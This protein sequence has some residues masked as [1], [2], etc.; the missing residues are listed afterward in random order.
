MEG[1]TPVSALLHAAT[2]VTAGVFLIIRSSFFIEYSE[3]VLNL[4]IIFGCITTFF[5]GLV[6]VYQYDIKKVI[7]YSTCS[8]LGY[9]FISSGLSNYQLAIFHLF[10]HAFFKALLFLSAGVIIHAFFG[11]QDMRK[12]GGNIFTITPFVYTYFVIGSLA[13]MGF[14]YLTGFFS[15]ELIIELGY[16]TIVIDM[17]FSYV[18]SVMSAVFTC[19]YSLNLLINTFINNNINGFKVNYKYFSNHTV[20]AHDTMLYALVPLFILSIFIGY[21]FKDLTIGSGSAT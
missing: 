21:L 15:K 3:N 19:V 9:M 13:I 4:L 20:D 11:E 1:P 17:Y 6:A 2:M 18:I 7:A 14:P 16:N 10:N 8:Q 5:A 12:Y